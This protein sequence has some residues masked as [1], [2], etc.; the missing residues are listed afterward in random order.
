MVCELWICTTTMLWYH[1]IVVHG[2]HDL[3]SIVGLS[4]VLAN[5]HGVDK[6]AHAS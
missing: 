1:G 4:L 5:V 2:R 3:L 6:C